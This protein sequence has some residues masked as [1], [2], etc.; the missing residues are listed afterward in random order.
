[1]HHNKFLILISFFVILFSCKKEVETIYTD[2]NFTTKNNTIVEINI[3]QASGNETIA[4]QINSEINKAIISAL[5]L[6]YPDEIT[7][8]SIEESI[9][10]FTEEFK[11]FKN[12]F[13]ETGEQWE[14]QIDGEVIYQSPELTT[15]AITSYINT[16]GAHGNL[17]I[18][19]LNF[20]SETGQP[21]K[22]NDL[23][24]NMEGFKTLSKSYFT[25]ATID[26][27]LLL[28]IESF[29]LPQNIGYSEDGIILLYN[30][31]E[32]APYSSGIIEFAVPFKAAAPFL[33][34]NS[35]F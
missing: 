6:G 8:T 32:I 22:N 7:S 15:I 30:T 2:T 5:H 9:A 3:P 20:N 23:F 19:F 33:V 31:Y 16:G 10:S 13:P 11:A 26:K 14:A 17:S 27:S 4:N 35:S 28:D 1:M 24:T 12:D 21:L 18:S 29:K 34:F 25:T